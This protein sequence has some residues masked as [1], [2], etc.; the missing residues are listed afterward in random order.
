M[1]VAVLQREGVRVRGRGACGTT[2]SVDELGSFR[3]RWVHVFEAARSRQGRQEPRLLLAKRIG[4]HWTRS[5]GATA[6][7]Q[8]GRVKYDTD[9]SVAALHRSYRGGRSGL[10][11]SAF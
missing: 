9:R 4:A 10:P 3:P 11:A 2:W 1:F 8:P 5:C 7:A 6:V